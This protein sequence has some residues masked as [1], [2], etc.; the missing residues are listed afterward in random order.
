M[1]SLWQ[2]LTGMKLDS[3]ILAIAVC[4]NLLSKAVL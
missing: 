4:K 1:T 2:K 3:S